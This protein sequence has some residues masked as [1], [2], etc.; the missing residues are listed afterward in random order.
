MARWK[1]HI[2]GLY[3][4]VGHD[5]H[6][7]GVWIFLQGF[8]DIFHLVDSLAVEIAP[9]K[10]VY[11]SESSPSLREVRIGFYHIDESLSGITDFFPVLLSVL[12]IFLKWPIIPDMHIVIEEVFYIRVSGEKPEKFVDNSFEK[13]FFGCQKRKPFRQI[14]PHL[15]TKNTPCSRSGPIAFIDP[16]VHNFAEEIEVLLFRV[17]HKRTN[18]ELNIFAIQQPFSYKGDPGYFL[19]EVL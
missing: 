3:G 10:T 19:D 11:R 6:P 1:E 5:E 9:L 15:V 18:Y 12:L 8:D 7:S 2:V 16:F 4:I 14:K 17:R 13:Y